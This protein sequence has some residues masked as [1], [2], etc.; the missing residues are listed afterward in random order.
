MSRMMKDYTDW[1]KISI[2]PSNMTAIEIPGK[3]NT[4]GTLETLDTQQG[5]FLINKRA[6]SNVSDI[7]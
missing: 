2:I 7:T 3:I 4:L 1:Q 5:V 6:P